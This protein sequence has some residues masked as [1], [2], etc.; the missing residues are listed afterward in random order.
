MLDV[1]GFIDIFRVI[2]QIENS[3][4]FS[5]TCMAFIIPGTHLTFQ[6]HG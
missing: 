1:T 4:L 6:Q 5:D 2:P 3:N